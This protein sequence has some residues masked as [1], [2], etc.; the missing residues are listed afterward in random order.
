WQIHDYHDHQTPADQVIAKRAKDRER[1]AKGR[2]KQ[3]R[4]PNTGRAESARNPHGRPQGLPGESGKSPPVQSPESRRH[5]HARDTHVS[6]GVVD[7]VTDDDKSSPPGHVERLAEAVA[8][9]R[10]IRLGGGHSRAWTHKTAASIDR[11]RLDE[12]AAETND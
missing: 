7:D 12:H 9:A 8:T 10:S 11:R 2:S 4:N 3:A 1:K 6:R 5:L